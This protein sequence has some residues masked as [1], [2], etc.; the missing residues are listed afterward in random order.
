M[1]GKR[2][3]HSRDN[4]P[5]YLPKR[6][7]STMKT[8]VTRKGT[9]IHRVMA[10]AWNAYAVIEGDGLLL[11][12]TGR[13]YWWPLL[14]RRVESLRRD[15]RLRAL[16]LT[17]THFDHAENAARI[18]AAYDIPIIV[19]QSEAAYL[20]SGESPLPDGTNWLM[21]RF[22]QSLGKRTQP[23]FRYHGIPADFTAGEHDSLVALGLRSSLMHTPGHTRGSLSIV[24]DDEIALVGDTLFSVFPWTVLHLWADDVPGMVKSWKK[25]LETPCS[26]FLPGHGGPI[27]RDLLEREY[28]RHARRL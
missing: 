15:G 22:M 4:I 13:G 5:T 24:I 25:L 10:G 14:R 6:G 7:G 28:A 8:W 3:E 16:I 1:I 9:V 17:H 23:F 27:R 21:R 26:L 2:Y 20:K 12:D 11:I 18:K 19:H